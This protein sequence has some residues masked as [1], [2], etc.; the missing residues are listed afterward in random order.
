M[1][2]ALRS[3]SLN[4]H[5]AG[6]QLLDLPVQM[7]AQFVV[8]ILLDP[9]RA[10]ERPGPYPQPIQQQPDHAFFRR[11]LTALEN[12]AQTSRSVSSCRRPA[13]VIR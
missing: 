13:A 10:K 4:R 7:T 3:A 2:A 6:G 5:A 8:Q 1:P 11:T 9:T 12:R